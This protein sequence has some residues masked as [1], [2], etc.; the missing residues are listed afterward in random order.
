[1]SVTENIY[2]TVH[3]LNIKNTKEKFMSTILQQLYNGE[4]IPVEQYSTVLEECRVM[5]RKHMENYDGFIQKLNSPLDEEFIKIMD[6]QLD[7]LPFDFFQM[8]SDGFK[9]GARMMIEIFKDEDKK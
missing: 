5:R 1:M 6:E 2:L 8:F 7:I 4:I 3:G 9:L